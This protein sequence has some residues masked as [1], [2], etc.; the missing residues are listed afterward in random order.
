[1][2]FSGYDSLSAAFPSMGLWPV[3]GRTLRG[4]EL[5]P[6]ETAPASETAPKDAARQSCEADEDDDRERCHT[7]DPKPGR[8]PER[9]TLGSTSAQG[10]SDRPSRSSRFERGSKLAAAGAAGRRTQRIC[11]AHDPELAASSE[12]TVMV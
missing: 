8:R 7:V 11:A 4:R 5:Q 2:T 12:A 10:L 6:L 3:F 9:A 1:M